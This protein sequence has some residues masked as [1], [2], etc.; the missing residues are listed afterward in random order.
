[1]ICQPASGVDEKMPIRRLEY[2]SLGVCGLTD[3][4]SAARALRGSRRAASQTKHKAQR[5]TP[6]AR[7]RQLQMLV[8]RHSASL[9]AATRKSIPAASR[10]YDRLV[11]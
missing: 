3:R 2:A 7:P 1:M 11:S 8:R 4:S 6:I 10:E 9:T 5:L